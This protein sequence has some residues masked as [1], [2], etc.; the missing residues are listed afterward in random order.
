MDQ[1][2]HFPF[3][4][5][6]DD[7]HF[8]I[9]DQKGTD[10]NRCSYRCTQT[11]SLEFTGQQD[12]AFQANTQ[13]CASFTGSQFVDL[14]YHYSLNSLE[15]LTQ[16]FPGQHDLQGLGS[17]DQNLRRILRLSS[18]FGCRRVSMPDRHTDS[19]FLTD[20]LQTA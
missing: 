1:Q 6:S 13:L 8:S 15:I 14:I 2:I 20:V 16:S 4:R 19:Q 12:Q 5:R 10:L 17:G 7:L 18:P 3:Q 11:Y 9:S